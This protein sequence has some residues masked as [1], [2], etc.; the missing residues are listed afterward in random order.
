MMWKETFKLQFGRLYLKN[1]V[2]DAFDW[3][4]QLLVMTKTEWYSQERQRYQLIAK[5]G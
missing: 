2:I 3:F 5:I 1:H 4:K